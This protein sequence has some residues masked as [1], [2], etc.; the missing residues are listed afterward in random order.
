MHVL[1]LGADDAYCCLAVDVC[2]LAYPNT[3]SGALLERPLNTRLDIT[4]ILR[5]LET[6]LPFLQQ[7]AIGLESEPDESILRPSARSV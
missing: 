2:V 5:N 1:G 6:S 4:C 7:P 3:G